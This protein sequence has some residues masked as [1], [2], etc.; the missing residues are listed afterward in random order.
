[1]NL[2]MTFF[3]KL[4]VLVYMGNFLNPDFQAVYANKNRDVDSDYEINRFTIKYLAVYL[5][6]SEE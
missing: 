5:R 3:K 4:P 1:M 6:N 2:A